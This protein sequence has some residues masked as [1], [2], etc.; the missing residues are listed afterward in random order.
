MRTPRTAAAALALAVAVVAAVIGVGSLPASANHV[1]WGG[2]D[3]PIRP[4]VQTFTDGAQ[5]TANFVFTNGA[6]VF[7]GQ[8][9]HCSG[10]G[11][12]TA[13]D[14]CDL[15]ADPLPIGTPV[16][17]AGFDGNTYAGTLAY[18][19]W[20]TMIGNGEAD[21]DTCAYNDFALVR[22]DPADHGNVNPS[23]PYWGGPNGIRTT[24]TTSGEAVYTYGNS[25]LRGGVSTLSPK[26]G[27]SLG[28]GS[29]GWNHT[30]YTA[31]PGVPGDSGSAVLDSQGRGL[32][33]LV[34]VAIAPFAGSN[35]VS[36]LNRVLGYAQANGGVGG[37]QLV[38]GTEPFNAN[39]VLGLPA[40]P[41]PLLGL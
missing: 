30:V 41:L 12:A 11:A 14:G 22:I 2:P 6:D 27:V 34:T 26:S 1:G 19:S 13:T 21:P 4:G 15:A 8:A 39:A 28:T 20:N 3:A 17:I 23:L 38:Q 35:G 37:V 9:A 24:A 16:E 10:Q 29:G 25:G 7:L 36:D 5:C 33:V 31:T 32:G 40:L 18:S